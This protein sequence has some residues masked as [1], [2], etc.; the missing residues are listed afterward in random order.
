D[1]IGLDRLQCQAEHDLSGSEFGAAGNQYPARQLPLTLRNGRVA[2]ELVRESFIAQLLR[3]NADART[4]G[5]A[6]LAEAGQNAFQKLFDA[7]G[8]DVVVLASGRRHDQSYSHGDAFDAKLLVARGR[9]SLR[10]L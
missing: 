4:V 8:L 7:V 3:P 5:F 10:V 9:L 6:N 1:A 2:V